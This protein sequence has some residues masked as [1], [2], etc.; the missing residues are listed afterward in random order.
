MCLLMKTS[1]TMKSRLSM[2]KIS[3]FINGEYLSYI[4]YENLQFV[5]AISVY[6]FVSFSLY[7]MLLMGSELLGVIVLQ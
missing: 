3:H 7:R 4:Y 6:H 5:V 1:S 2:F